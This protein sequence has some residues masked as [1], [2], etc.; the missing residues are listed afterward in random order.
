[1][2][3]KHSPSKGLAKSALAG[4]TWQYVSIFSQ[5]L[6]NL[7][8]LGILSR[9]LS[10]DDFG[11]M[12]IAAVFIGLAEMFSEL[13]VGPAIIQRL[14][15]NENHK[16]VGLTIAFLLGM[17]MVVI[18]WA[19]AP[20]IA[21]FFNADQVT[22]VLR[23]VSFNFLIGSF[24]VV[25][26]AL[27]KRK[28]LFK[29]L[30]VINVIAYTLGYGVV[31][32][33]M[34][35]SGYGVWALV[36]ATLSQSLINS[37]LAL[38]VERF[39]LKLSL[40]RQE[41]RELV[42]FGGGLTLARL[43][44]Y[45]AANGDYFVVGRFLGTGPLGI[46]TRAFRLMKIPKSYL[47]KALDSVLFPVMAKI[48]E[49]IKR[50]RKTYY[51]SIALISILCAP[52]GVFMVILAPEIV[53]VVLGAQWAEVIVPLQILAIG[54]L[55]QVSYKID[56][57]VARALGAVYERSLRDGI[58]MVAIV[59]GSWVGLRWGLAGVAFGV[60]GAVI[61]NSL[62]AMQMSLRLLECSLME[63]IKAQ[64]PGVV[65]AIVTAIVALPT[66]SLL[67]SNGSPDWFILIVS[68]LVT[69]LILLGLFFWR[70]QK[71]LGVYGT[72]ALVLLVNSV[73]KRFVPKIVLQWFDAR[74]IEGVV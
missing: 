50:F 46:Y 37:I 3:K 52:L 2:A 64:I 27:L 44:N 14:D 48:Q 17:V 56:N 62:M 16:R 72:G 23:G 71:F 41:L 70:P 59:I 29:K 68:A 30:M 8:I 51:I 47:G 9:L 67:L 55:P 20:L 73:P 42:Y 1:M 7:I 21:I 74:M 63:Y 43:F 18:L 58:Y 39:P 53:K 40:A 11:V 57:S 6:L 38:W 10:P 28:L 33:V 24:G 12:G 4:M 32:V 45:G 36:G 49:D 13:G 60:L 26:I 54:V 34:A 35:Y 65:L 66:R 15:L 19:T 69:G 61:L 22:R 31:G 25:S 5:G